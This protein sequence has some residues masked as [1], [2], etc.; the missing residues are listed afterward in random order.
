MIK[1]DLK[2]EIEVVEVKC[3]EVRLLVEKWFTDHFTNNAIAGATA[4]RNELH[5][6]KEKLVALLEHKHK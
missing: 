4:F 5:A 6:A 3:S 2:D 1:K